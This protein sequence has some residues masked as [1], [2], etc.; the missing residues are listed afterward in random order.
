V[1]ANWTS[2]RAGAVTELDAEAER[3]WGEVQAGWQDPARH[4]AFVKHCSA[5]GLLAAAGRRYRL[6]LDEAP[7]DAEAARMQQRILT[8]AA[9]ALAP[10]A[11]QRPAAAARGRFLL[12][13][14]IIGV[15][16]G[17]VGSLV[18]RALR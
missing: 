3:L 15:A 10:L 4:D 18:W 14:V 1:F 5:A 11:A 16:A 12:W 9:A 7:G 8:M 17:I 13:A 6:R 2:A